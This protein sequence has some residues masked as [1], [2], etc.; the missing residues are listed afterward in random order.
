MTKKYLNY[1]RGM[2]LKNL[3]EEI[4]EHSKSSADIDAF[5][6]LIKQEQRNLL[7]NKTQ[8]WNHTVSDYCYFDFL[9]LIE[10]TISKE[11]ELQEIV[12]ISGKIEKLTRKRIYI[13]FLT[14]EPACWGSLE[15]LYNAT[16]MDEAFDAALVYTPFKHVN[17]LNEEDYFNYYSE[18]L[19]LPVIRHNEYCIEN[20]SPDIVVMIK[21]YGNIPEAYTTKNL[22]Y[23]VPRVVYIPYGMEVTVD[24][25][26]FGFQYYTHYKAWRHCA[27][28]PAV[29]DYGREYGLCNGN[30]IRVWG[31]PK[32]DYYRE[33]YKKKNIPEEWIKKINGR[34]TILWT[35]HHLID[36]D[37]DGTGSWLIWGEKFL[38]FALKSQNVA[39]IFRPHPLMFGALVG[40]GYMSQD[41][42]DST[43]LTIKNSDN[44]IWDDCLSYQEAFYAADAIV[45]DGTTFSIEFLY[46]EK[47]IL[48]TP[49]NLQSFYYYQD[50]LNSYYI[51]EKF[52][53]ITTFVKMVAEGEDPL[54][55]K[56]ISMKEKVLYIP[57]DISV[58][59][60]I[61]NNIEKDLEY[62]CQQTYKK[63]CEFKMLDYEDSYEVNEEL[64]NMPL[65]S[66]IVL[67]YKN[68]AIM[69]PMLNSIFIQNYP[70]I[71]LVVSDDGSEDFDVEKVIEYINKN[72]RHNIEDVV[73]RKNE[74]NMGTVKHI[75]KILREAKGD[76]IIFTAAD[77][78]FVGVDV[79]SRYVSGFLEN[80]D[81]C[82]LVA[83]CNIVTADYKRTI[84]VTPTAIDEKTF[85]TNDSQRIFSRW[86]RRGMAIP[87][88]MAFRKDAFEKVGGIDLD[89]RYLEDWPLVLKLLRSGNTPI[90]LP[91]VTAN[92]ST[93][94]VTNSNQRYGIE[95]RKAFYNDKELIF[96]KEVN[97][98]IRLLSDEDK[99]ALKL[100]RKEIMARNYFLDIDYAGAS[101]LEKI[102]L[103][104]R[105]PYAYRWAFENLFMAKRTMIQR[106]KMIAISQIL[107]LLSMIFLQYSGLGYFKVLFNVIGVL[108]LIVAILLFVFAFI[109]YPLDKYYLNK[110]DLRKW[111]VN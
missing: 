102:L 104:M 77:D 16:V 34:K 8:F 4:I 62:E 21:P 97:P 31:H 55:Q 105:K 78:R 7:K 58:S 61:L 83:R 13:L 2:F 63:A 74:F 36:L 10:K 107:F 48:L 38:D 47:P 33:E 9:D 15:N 11:F 76:Y 14:Q 45:T 66:V 54:L 28:G 27:Y 69:N 84:Y 12:T 88:C 89:Y 53:D 85:F 72:K 75:D 51:T 92:H 80:P 91:I 30:N 68:S 56:R 50:M 37:G 93:G 98:H 87:C 24:L 19:N 59:K 82:W 86:A 46:T 94:G 81:K 101:S 43:I 103:F 71:Q 41:E 32:A 95:V 99:K 108:N 25:I 70:R 17:Y 29:L 79:F 42:V 73:V 39:F 3:C 23:V 26:K 67:C 100:Y 44:I 64:P 52:S 90:Y 20:T 57:K 109:S 5:K 1:T 49:R 106:K 111:L 96:T 65:L 35:P 60:N 6:E 110:R 40:G 18:T 22:Q